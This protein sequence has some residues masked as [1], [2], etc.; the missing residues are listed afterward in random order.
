MRP[1]LELF[2][3]VRFILCGSATAGVYQ[4]TLGNILSL[5]TVASCRLHIT[6]GN[7]DPS[8]SQ[9]SILC[10]AMSP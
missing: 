9:I 5:E 8:T 3:Q 2:S 4:L 6:S 7:G 1:S 10:Q